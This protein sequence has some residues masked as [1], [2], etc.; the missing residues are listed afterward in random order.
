MAELLLSH[1]ASREIESDDGRTPVEMARLKGHE[2]LEAL[3]GYEG[4]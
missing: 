1:G 2:E 4:G 3:L